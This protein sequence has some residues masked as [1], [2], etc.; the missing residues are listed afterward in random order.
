MMR[1]Q[2]IKLLMG[3][4]GGD[5]AFGGGTCIV[6]KIFGGML[7]GNE[8]KVDLTGGDNPFN[9]GYK[10]HANGGMIN[11]PTLALIGENATKNPEVIFNRDQFTDQI[12]NTVSATINRMGNIGSMGNPSASSQRKEIVVKVELSGIVE[13]Q[14]GFD[15]QLI[16]LPNLIKNVVLQSINEDNDVQRS[17]QQVTVE[18]TM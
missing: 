1:N 9:V 18:G 11:S 17:I 2:V 5:N 7:G 10:A 16:Q 14:S 6:T 4:F 3:G 8:S 12:Q 15:E 13:S